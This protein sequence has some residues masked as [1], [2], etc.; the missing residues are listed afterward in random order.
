MRTD[1]LREVGGFPEVLTEDAYL[2]LLL[3]ERN[4]RFGLVAPSSRR[5]RRVTCGRI[6]SSGCDGTA[7]T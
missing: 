5:R 3:T 6:S 7:A 1:V 2:G 4:K